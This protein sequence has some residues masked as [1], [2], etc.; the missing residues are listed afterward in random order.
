MTGQHLA[1]QLADKLYVVSNSIPNFPENF[2][3]TKIHQ[4]S[5]KSN[6][7]QNTHI[8]HPISHKCQK[9]SL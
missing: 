4:L 6:T 7:P 3:E 9:Q 2:C 1:F 8:S 5:E